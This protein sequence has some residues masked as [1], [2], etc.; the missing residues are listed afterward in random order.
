MSKP[1]TDFSLNDFC[2][3]GK[4]AMITG[5]NQGLGVA[6][7]IALAKAGADIFIPHF[8][9]EIAEIKK[10]IEGIGRKVGFLQGDLTDDAYR[11][12]C[13]KACLDM[14]GKIDI[15][16]NNA[17]NNYIAP[18]LD[19]PDEKWK[20]VIELQLEAVHYLSR[21]VA[22]VMKKQGGGK[23]INIAS[24]LSFA[25]DI[26]ATAYTVAKHGIIGMTRS[27]AAELGK[28]NIT[29]NA[30]APGFFY[31]PMA[32]MLSREMPELYTKVCDRTPMCVNDS[33]GDLYN[34]MGTA[35]YLSS[36]A[37]DYVTGTVIVVDGG[38]KAQ[39][40]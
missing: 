28:Y 24:A 9:D 29:C 3:K 11:K 26:G 16:I 35:V 39:M 2:L 23:I 15:L 32:E 6:Y 27:Y 36:S 25:A 22:Q 17:G 21:E 33:W 31:T 10:T 14:F 38:F 12:D 37:A 18:L 40:I 4:V 19:F 20:Q 34:I 13:V 7:A 5:A 30:I 1:L 8:T